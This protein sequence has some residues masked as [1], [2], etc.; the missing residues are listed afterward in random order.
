MKPTTMAII[1]IILVLLF[2][3]IVF[4]FV[5]NKPMNELWGSI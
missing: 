5:G 3:W 1:I 4:T 2:L